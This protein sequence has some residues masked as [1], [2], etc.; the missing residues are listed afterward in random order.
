MD[1]TPSPSELEKL[2]KTHLVGIIKASTE[3]LE[4]RIQQAERKS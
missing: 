4:K 1:S 2:P 3:Q